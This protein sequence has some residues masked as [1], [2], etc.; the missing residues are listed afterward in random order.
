M[1]EHNCS[2]IE[3]EILALAVRKGGIGV[4]NPCNEAPLEYQASRKIAAPLV[5]RIELQMH[6]IP[7][8]SEIQ[9]LKQDAGKEKNSVLSERVESV[10]K[11]ASPKVHR[12]IELAS[13]KGASSWLIVIPMSEIDC[14][15]S[16]PEF[17]DA[18]KLRCNWPIKDNPTRRACRDL[19]LH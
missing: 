7:D 19:F 12:M 14:A 1:A 13:E 10:V 8:D 4:A 5:K 15:L 17:R 6:E 3:R 18:L 2:L 9:V 11:N 16:K